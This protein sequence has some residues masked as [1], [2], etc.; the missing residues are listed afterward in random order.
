MHNTNI[1]GQPKAPLAHMMR[2]KKL[3]EYIGQE[4][5]VG[6]KTPFY[7]EITTG[8]LKSMILY[9]PAGCGKTSLAEVIANTCS[10]AFEQLSATSAGVKDIREVINRARE[11]QVSGGKTILFI[12]E[13][14]RFNKGQQDVLLPAVED[15]TVVFIGATT[16]NPFFSLNSPLISRSRLYILKPLSRKDLVQIIRRTLSD[17]ENGIGNQ[18]ISVSQEVQED[19]A[20]A[21]N[22]DARRAL[23]LLEMAANMVA[24]GA[25]IT[26]E[27]VQGL[28]KGPILNYDKRS[29]E[30]YDTISAFIKSMRGS[31]VNAALFWMAKMIEGGEDPRFIAR[32]IVIFASEDVGNADPHALMVAIS[33]AQAVE[34]VGLPECS[35]NLTQAVIYMSLAP[36]SNTVIRAYNA[37]VSDV[38]NN[39]LA[40]VPPHLRDSHYPGAK[41]LGHG[42]SYKYP[43][44]YPNAQVDQQYLPDKLHD[45]NYHTPSDIGI[46]KKLATRRLNRNDPPPS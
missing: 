2:P 26:R 34:F 41:R 38:R 31:D 9:G 8:T 5:I 35:L 1:S 33:A 37:V 46:E 4:D 30:H 32:R 27:L 10:S 23:T 25:E 3:D 18:R 19:L 44:D 36:K 13:V 28:V 6:A 42:H 15:G 45:K 16:E 20:S 17:K 14:H 39:P 22:G 12:D 21:A 7:K 40:K 24:P 11:N 29:D 43:H